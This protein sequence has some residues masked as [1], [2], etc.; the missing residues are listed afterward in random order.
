MVTDVGADFQRWDGLDSASPWKHSGE[1]SEA[2][3]SLSSWAP[4]RAGSQLD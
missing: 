3:K 4:A 1:R 2:I